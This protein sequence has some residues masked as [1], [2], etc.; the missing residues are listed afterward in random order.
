[1]VC[2]GNICRSP[3][4]E[5]VFRAEAERQGLTGQYAFDSAGTAAWHI[6]KAPD[7][8]SQQAAAK[9]GL[10]LSGLR[11]R[12]L[13]LEDFQRFDYLLVMDQQNLLDVQARCPKG[14][15]AI[16]AKALTYRPKQPSNSQPEI[17]DVPDPYYGG[18]T[19][20]EQVLALLE[21][22]AIGFLASDQQAAKS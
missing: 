12:Q 7:I 14:S 3:T 10:S 1:M 13:Q 8:R 17:T 19:G 11:A 2:L 20:F 4:A 16:I 6:G 15:G 21:T 9:R 5:A 18:E 22:A